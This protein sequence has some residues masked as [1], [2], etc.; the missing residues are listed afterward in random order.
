MSD[1][2]YSTDT[3]AWNVEYGS[4]FSLLRTSWLG[5]SESLGYWFISPCSASANKVLGWDCFGF[6]KCVDAYRI[7]ALRPTLNLKSTAMVIS[8]DGSYNNPYKLLEN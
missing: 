6:A 3:S 1:F 4:D 5:N 7:A 8:G 2:I